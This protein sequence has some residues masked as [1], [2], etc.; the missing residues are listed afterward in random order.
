MNIVYTESGRAELDAF[1]ME[2]KRVLEQVISERKYVIGDQLLEITASDIKQSA[3]SIRAIRKSTYRFDS[4]QMATKLYLVVG[5]AT[6]LYG[7]FY[8]QIREMFHGDPK[9]V[10]IVG[11]GVA[12]IL[13]S[14]VMN[15]MLSARI[16]R[17]KRMEL[18]STEVTKHEENMI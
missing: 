5:V 4:I 6:A 11:A 14:I 3:S 13:V 1:L 16:Q 8:T 10:L 2:Q 18:L 15:M 17:M 12:M 9:R 7:L